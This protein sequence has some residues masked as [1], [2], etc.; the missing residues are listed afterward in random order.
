MFYLDWLAPL[1]VFLVLSISACAEPQSNHDPLAFHSAQPTTPQPSSNELNQTFTSDQN[2]Q[3]TLYPGQVE[4][5]NKNSIEERAVVS[6]NRMGAAQPVYGMVWIT[7]KTKVDPS[8]RRV[9]FT[10]VRI[11]KS[12]FPSDTE[13]SASVLKTLRQNQ[14]RVLKPVALDSLQ[15]NFA[16]EKVESENKQIPLRNG[17]PKIVVK[18]SPTLL[19]LVDGAPV[20]RDAGVPKLMRVINT[21]ALILFDSE[22]GRYFFYMGDHWMDALTLQGPWIETDQPSPRLEDAKKIAVAQKQVDLLNE[23]DSPL[24]KQLAQHIIPEI[25]V[26]TEPTEILET[27][28][29]PQLKS[30]SGT[31]LL[32]VSNSEQDIFLNQTDQAYYVLL[33]GRWYKSKSLEGPWRY[34]AANQL[35]KD[36]AKIPETHRRGSVLASVPGTQQA[37]EAKISNDLP[38]TAR[39]DRNQAS[40]EVK[41]D[42]DPHFVPIE[43]TSLQYAENSK[44]PVIKV[45]SHLYFAL[46][47][48][49]WFVASEPQG[50]WDVATHVP[51]A[52]YS[53]PASSPIYY[54][55]YVRIYDANRDSVYV[56][57]TPGY[58]GTYC[59]SDGVVVYGTGYYYPPWIGTYWIGPPVTF[60]VGFTWGF[61]GGFYA[62]PAFYP[63]WGPWWSVPVYIGYPYA[64]TGAVP[65]G[66]GTVYQGWSSGVVQTQNPAPFQSAY[67]GK[68]G[69]WQMGPAAQ[70]GQMGGQAQPQPPASAFN[71]PPA[72]PPPMSAP[73]PAPAA[74]PPV[75]PAPPPIPPSAPAV[76]GALSHGFSGGG[77]HWSGHK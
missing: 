19:V 67:V 35:P 37:G 61:G 75:A 17:P 66:Q 16:I 20:L 30:I 58:L 64:V 59:C 1:S 8:S 5:L 56:G 11:T 18:R 15:S 7:A 3:I 14:S 36:F 46:Q 53:I 55:T 48:G 39:V 51:S 21:R 65:V 25:Y 12:S 2:E 50:P 10:Q 45:D 57:Y 44:T 43:E 62:G 26:S 72:A 49:V 47:S 31:S 23:P 68:G 4:K 6:V 74:P 40:I 9:S 76:S 13:L 42:G 33:S 27:E 24:M 28:G 71:P 73:A 32:F 22:K 70:A 41:Y 54:V 77:G 38:Q 52:I 29:K 34:I 60:G 63:W 69:T